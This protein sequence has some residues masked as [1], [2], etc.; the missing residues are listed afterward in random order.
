MGGGTEVLGRVVAFDACSQDGELE[1]MVVDAAVHVVAVAALAVGNRGVPDLRAEVTPM[2]ASAGVRKVHAD[3]HF[4]CR[5]MATLAGALLKR[6]MDGQ[7]PDRRRA[8]RG[9]RLGLRRLARRLGGTL[10]R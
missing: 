7:E 4:L 10:G 8:H 2:T 6:P 5:V 3:R 9:R 1:K